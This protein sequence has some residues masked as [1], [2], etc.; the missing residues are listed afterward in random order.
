MNHTE[1]T[2]SSAIGD[3][4]SDNIITGQE[5]CAGGACGDEAEVEEGGG[6]GTGEGCGEGSFYGDGTWWAEPGCSCDSRSLG[7][8]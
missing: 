7:H 8:C 5:N 2:T 3:G 1:S 4:S 6:G